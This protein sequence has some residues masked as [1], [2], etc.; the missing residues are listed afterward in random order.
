MRR[1]AQDIA[2][3]LKADIER[4]TNHDRAT[5]WFNKKLITTFLIRR[6]TH[7]RHGHLPDRLFLTRHDTLLLAR[8]SISREKY[9]EM[10]AD[11]LADGG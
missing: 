1:E 2:C 9:F 11:K 6:G 4:L 7:A 3:K 10:I 8:C 5:V